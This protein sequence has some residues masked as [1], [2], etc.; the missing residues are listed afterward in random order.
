[1]EDTTHHIQQQLPRVY[2]HELVQV[3]LEQPYCRI[4]N[5]VERD[6]AKR[7]TAS[8]YLQQLCEIGVLKEIRAGREKLFVHPKLVRLMTEDSNEVAPYPAS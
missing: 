1:M 7:Q 2:S 3:I 6:I 8:S 5:L 4:N